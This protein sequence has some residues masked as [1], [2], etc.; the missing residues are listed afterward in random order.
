MQAFSTVLS[1]EFAIKGACPLP[2]M[3]GATQRQAMERGKA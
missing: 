2:E 3:A 1:K